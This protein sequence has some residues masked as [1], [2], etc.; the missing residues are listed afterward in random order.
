MTAQLKEIL[1]YKGRRHNMATL[2]LEKYFSKR[3]DLHHKIGTGNTACWRGY[4]GVWK[5]VDGK[6]YLIELKLNLTGGE[7][8]GF[9]YL[10]PD[11]QKVFAEWYSGEVKIQAGDMLHYVHMG[12]ESVYEKDIFLKFQKGELIGKR[13]VDN[14]KSAE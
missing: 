4:R 2:P 14:R 13:V 5:V 10:F 11:Q 9:D 3:V 12:Y 8:V 6:L 1:I 7:R